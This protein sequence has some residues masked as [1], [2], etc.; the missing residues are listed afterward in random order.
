[1]TDHHIRSS[2]RAARFIYVR[3]NV[4]IAPNLAWRVVP[5]DTLDVHLGERRIALFTVTNLSNRPSLG[6]IAFDISP[7]AALKYYNKIED[8]CF[9]EQILM[10]QERKKLQEVF[11]IDPAINDDVDIGR[12]ENVFVTY[13]FVNQGRFALKKYLRA[14][15]Y[16]G[17][18]RK[19]A[20]WL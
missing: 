12:I 10:P 4:T 19:S 17:R 5:P 13:H 8:I 18:F 9:S 14:N 11:T 3:I 20:R 16:S 2:G 7:V 1:M 15:G 6:T